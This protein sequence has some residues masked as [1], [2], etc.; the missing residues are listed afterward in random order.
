[1]GGLRFLEEKMFSSL[2]HH[3]NRLR[4]QA[5][6]SKPVITMSLCVSG[7]R[8]QY[9]PKGCSLRHARGGYCWRE[10]EMAQPTVTAWARLLFRVVTA[11]RVRRQTPKSR[12]RIL[13]LSPVKMEKLVSTYKFHHTARCHNPGRHRRLQCHEN[14]NSHKVAPFNHDLQNCICSAKEAHKAF[15]NTTLHFR[16]WHI[17]MN[18]KAFWKCYKQISKK[19]FRDPFQASNKIRH[20]YSIHRSLTRRNGTKGQTLC[21]LNSLII[22]RCFVILRCCIEVWYFVECTEIC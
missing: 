21:C 16:W 11:V 7:V 8:R 19:P 3:R 20:I 4:T 9:L 15:K 22:P 1:M 14:L 13:P 18:P 6:C 12:S 17:L 5:K 2:A 10:K